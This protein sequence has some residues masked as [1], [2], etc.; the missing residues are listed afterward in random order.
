MLRSIFQSSSYAVRP[1]LG[2]E[3]C[4]CHRDLPAR[5]SSS[6]SIGAST[7][8]RVHRSPSASRRADESSPT[9]AEGSSSGSDASPAPRSETPAAT[10]SASESR[11]P[12]LGGFFNPYRARAKLPEH[13]I[14]VHASPNNTIITVTTPEGNPLF[15]SSGGTAGFRKGAR[16]GYE[17]GYRAS[18]QAFRE[19][20]Q[21]REQWRVSGIEVLFKGF[22]QGR[23][24]FFRALIAAEGSKTRELV[25]RVTDATSIKIGGVRP[26]KRR[27]L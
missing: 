18:F 26:K 25:R 4:S 7:P 5:A 19:I 17:A 12:G 8:S 13:K 6:T 22:G 11:L 20:Q 10:S 1:R 2:L 9:S 23:E 21:H 16:S 14:H 15:S 24:A 3:R 27:M